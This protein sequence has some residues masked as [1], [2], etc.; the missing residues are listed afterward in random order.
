VQEKGIYGVPDLVVEILSPK[1]TLADIVALEADYRS[2][3]ASEIWFIDQK[4][5]QVR[6]LQ[7]RGERYQEEVISKGV[8]RSEVVE[9][10]WLKVE[11]LFAKPLPL[12]LDTLTQ[13]LEGEEQ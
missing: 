7:K 9:G 10:F 11:W 3:G 6:V 12:R 2:I 8:M 5:K 13:I 1:D 4:R